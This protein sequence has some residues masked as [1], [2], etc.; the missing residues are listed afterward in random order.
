MTFLMLPS[1]LRMGARPL[2]TTSSPPSR[3][4]PSTS[5]S[6]GAKPLENLGAF[7]WYLPLSD[8]PQGHTDEVDNAVFSPD[9]RRVLTASGHNTA[10]FWKAD[11]GE[12]LVTFQGHTGRVTSA[13]FSPEGQHALTASGG[14][15][16][17]L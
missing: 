7:P 14:K 17:R 13:V 5:Y 3:I 11:S 10:R 4:G 1:G 2:S 6:I 9:S 12:L 16:A 8:S 15:T